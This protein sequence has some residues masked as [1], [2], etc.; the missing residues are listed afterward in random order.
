[1]RM[2][3]KRTTLTRRLMHDVSGSSVREL[4]RID[5]HLT[6]TSYIAN[7]NTWSITDIGSQEEVAAKQTQV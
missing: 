1:M 3:A 7:G 2:Q 4:H 6:T 5:L